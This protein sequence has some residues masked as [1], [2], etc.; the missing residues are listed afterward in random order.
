MTKRHPGIAG[1]TRK[2]TEGRAR[3]ERESARKRERA[4][5]RARESES[6]RDRERE[7]TR[8]EKWGASLTKLNSTLT[9]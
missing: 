6:E 3:E 1:E 9:H 8:R 7:R 2:G 5:A 4:R